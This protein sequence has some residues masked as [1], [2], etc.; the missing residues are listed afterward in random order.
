MEK[1][2]FFGRRSPEAQRLLTSKEE[3][4]KYA[5]RRCTARSKRSGEQCQNWAVEGYDKCRMHSGARVTAGKVNAS[6]DGGDLVGFSDLKKKGKYSDSV[7]GTLKARYEE[8]I[9][10][11]DLSTLV[12][13]LGLT[14]SRIAQILEKLGT[15]ETSDLWESL[16]DKWTEF[17]MA[18]RL[19][20]TESQNGILPQLNRLIQQGASTS[21]QWEELFTIMEKRRKMIETENKRVATNRDMIPVETAVLMI[22]MVIET[23]R[24]STLKYADK[25]TAQAILTDAQSTYEK[26]V[27]PG[28]N[29]R[30]SDAIVDGEYSAR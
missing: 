12:N 23:T 25:K 7:I 1:G 24:L 10:H 17:M 13:E 9:A 26:L 6:Y 2:K 21:S 11:E 14:D 29:N 19:G 3:H 22:N 20:D 15:G 27:G 28:R 18:V 5:E 16:R 4:P 30:P 8:A